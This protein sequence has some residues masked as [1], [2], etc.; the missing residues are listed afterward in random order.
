MAAEYR[1][2][3]DVHHRHY[4]SCSGRPVLNSTRRV[5]FCQLKMATGLQPVATM[6][7]LTNTT[8]HNRLRCEHH[9]KALGIGI[10]AD[11]FTRSFSTSVDHMV[12][13]FNEIVESPDV[14]IDPEHV[15]SREGVDVPNTP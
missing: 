5:V 9:T 7:F 8:G 11:K 6:A 10:A 12:V 14:D 3:K 13:A 1:S 4:R 2:E 15:I